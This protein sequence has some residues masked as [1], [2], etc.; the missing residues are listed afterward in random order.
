MDEPSAAERATRLSNLVRTAPPFVGRREELAWLEQLLRESCGGQPRVV[1]LPGDAGIG[2]TR[3]LQEVRSGAVR[4]G[5][6]VGYG[7]GYEDLTLPYLPFIEIFHSLLGR[8]SDD[9]E[10]TIGAD[11]EVIRWLLHR[12]QALPQVAT[13]PST[14]SDQDKFR[15][16][17]AVTRTIIALAQ[18]RPTVIV[19]DDLHWADRSSIDLFG[20]LVFTVADAAM[21]E[22][23]PLLIVGSYR[24]VE[25][26]THL[27][28]LIARVQRETICRSYTLP[29]LNESEIHELVQ[30]LGLLRPSHQLIATV[31]GATQGNPLFIQEVLH[32]LMQEDALRERG[33]YVV[34]TTAAADLRLP[35]QVTG[36][37]VRRMHRLSAEWWRI[38]TMA[39]FLGDHFSLRDL[40]AVS[41]VGEDELLN[42]LEE[43]MRQRL[44][45]SEGEAFRFAHPLIRQVFYQEPSLPRRQRIHAQIAVTLERLY[46][47]DLEAHLLGIAHHLIRAGA[48]AEASKVVEYARRAGDQALKLFAWGEAAHY[49]EAALS[50]AESGGALT[51]QERADLH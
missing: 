16:F 29:G 35:D 34:A 40:A 10:R 12:D 13:F 47:D 45:Q 7:R 31:S 36:A 39:S 18:R 4:D 26:E 17:F 44:L 38:L 49:Y 42:S 19:V 15:L 5:L 21:R 22:Q 43:G 24:P 30:G 27:G 33:G 9:L 1:L 8:I 20:H 14:Q 46:A 11:A 51:T 23:A 2:K 3:L 50:A 25:P 37:I 32:H 6:Q 41:A 48:A 28:R